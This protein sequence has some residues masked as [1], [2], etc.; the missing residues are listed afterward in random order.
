MKAGKAARMKSILAGF[1]ILPALAGCGPAKETV[2]KAAEKAE[3]FDTSPVKLS[4]FPAVGIEE[5]DVN[6]LFIEPVKKKYPHIDIE[7]LKP[8]KGTM[9]QDLVAAGQPPD[10]LYTWNGGLST[11]QAYDLLVDM[12]PLAA[13]HGADLSR[14]EPVV[15]DSIRVLSGQRELYA[16]PFTVQ[17]NAIYYNKDLFD[18]FGVPYPSDGMTWEETI[19]L[20][21]RV[22]RSEGGV[23]YRGL[24][25][26]AVSRL[27][28]PLGITYVNSGKERSAIDTD[29]WRRVF[30][31]AR[32]IYS[33]PGNKPGNFLNANAKPAFLK[34]QNLAMITTINLLNLALEEA[35]AVGLNWDVA[36]Y[37]SY[38]EK[39]NVY[40][41]VDAHVL[42]I[43]K[44]SKHKD[45]AMQVLQ[46]VTSDEV[47]LLSARTTARLS[48]LQN[49]EMKKQL[50]ADMPFLKGKRL[51]SIFK[52]SPVPAP[53]YSRYEDS[54]VNQIVLKS[55]E[56]YF[57]GQDMNSAL[58][59]ADQ[60][61]NRHI[62]DSKSK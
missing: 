47:Q 15:L 18:R 49:P 52:S 28:K 42:A 30:E 3:A 21:K 37:P 38:K 48:P 34:D 43:T 40:G 16:L 12:T 44:T 20:A 61:I 6:R 27:S 24:D 32:S 7:L 13:R 25:P 35:A 8:G 45:Q 10:L 41:H 22:T 39:P 62:E 1:C 55:F 17:F 57:N 19:E 2:E 9:I 11:F 23:S 33:I 51:E 60:K 58:R 59:D 53:A 4:L 56:A 54:A 50:G 46:V 5:K 26:E 14:F 31:L 36:Q 29:E